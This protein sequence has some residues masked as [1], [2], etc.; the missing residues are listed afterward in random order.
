MNP[1]KLLPLSLLGLAIFWTGMAGAAIAGDSVPG[2]FPRS[3]PPEALW[4]LDRANLSNADWHLAA[5]VQG[6][7]NRE[8]PCLYLVDS[9]AKTK[10]AETFL[11]FY[12]SEY[13]VK[14]AGELG[15]DQALQKFAGLFR[16]YAVFSFE[17][18]WTVDIADTYCSLHDCLPVTAEQEARARAAGLVRV[19][20]F[21]GRWPGTADSSR[22]AL[23][24]L[25][26]R[27]SKKIVASLSP[28]VHT[29]RDYFFANR[30]YTFYLAA[31]GA[32]YWRL[33]DHML[34]LPPNIPTMGYIARNGIEEWI[35][36]YTLAG[37]GKFMIPTD[38]VP[39]LS[40]HSG[41][42]IQPL[43][44]IEPWPEPPDLRGKLGVVFA[45][46]DGDNLHIEAEYYLRPD[47][48]LDPRRGE[49]KVAWSVAP[50]LYELAPG[51]MRYYYRTRTPNDFFVA[52]SG[53]G[54]TFPSAL[55]D[56]QYF[57]DLSLRYLKLTGL[58]VLWTL[59]PLLYFSPL[60]LAPV[61]R[62]LGADGYTRGVLAG[63]APAIDG[64]NWSRL[65]GYPPVL[66]SKANYFASETE[67]LMRTL[68][69][70][71]ACVP[72][73]GKVVFYAVNGWEVS[74]EDLLGM[75]ARLEREGAVLLSPPEAFGLIEKWRK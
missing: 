74:Y 17:E 55:K 13:G 4:L 60:S 62:P 70:D 21:R 43:P 26:P 66:Y 41:I 54:Y 47:G 5:I 61:L 52:L 37:A 44:Q 35:V 39:N 75:A 8:R 24:E 33:R 31:S 71:A 58:D 11:A 69:A 23:R 34:R 27:C 67:T 1:K 73:R 10:G 29:C 56:K 59:D 53:A 7:A 45:L 46:T 14:T 65:P 51:I 42:P 36:E 48:W 3:A 50:E 2:I 63:Y 19:E 25:F 9:K 32:D 6:M 68:R 28:T 49:I 15:L 72:P 57:A 40:V 30:I 38:Q 18:P 16:G 22:W 64:R 20:D 12:A